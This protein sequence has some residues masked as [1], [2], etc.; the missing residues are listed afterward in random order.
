MNPSQYY[1]H[2]IW[3]HSYQDPYYFIEKHKLLILNSHHL[4][5]ISVWLSIN[6]PCIILV[7]SGCQFSISIYSE[8]CHIVLAWL[9]TIYCILHCSQWV[10]GWV[11]YMLV[12]VSRHW[13]QQIN[14]L[15]P[16]QNP[17]RCSFI[18]SSF[19][20]LLDSSD[21]FPQYCC[22]AIR[23]VPRGEVHGWMSPPVRISKKFN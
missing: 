1:F 14:M 19:H 23:R 9:D 20:L 16:P 21:F 18:F 2:F 4:S 17:G 5:Q 6:F 7:D 10:V 8:E 13:S 11:G 3:L 12:D 15:L 22:P